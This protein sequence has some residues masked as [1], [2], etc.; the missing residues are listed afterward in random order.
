M[1]RVLDLLEELLK[2]KRYRYERLDGSTSSSSRLAAV[3]R[4]KR[5]SCQRF[6]MLLSTRAGGLGL[7]LTA[8]DI[9]IIFDSDWNPQNDLQAMARAHRIGQQRSVKIY[10]LLTAKTYEMHMFHS[11]SLKL[12]LERAVLSQNREQGDDN[13]DSK[14]KKKSDRE[15]Q[16]KEIDE[17]LKKG[18]YDVFR[19]DD[20]AEAEKF[21]E[22]D[23]DQLLENS[24]KKVTYGASSTSSL[25]NG[26]GSFSKASFVTDTGSGEKDVDLDDPD[27]WAKAVGL[28]APVE[29]PGDV[30]AML[31]DGVKRS[32][33]QVQVY[34]PYAETAAA[35]KLKMEK[36]AMEK[37][38][39]K[40]E[41]ER[42]R[43]E[44]KMKKEALKEKKK[45]EKEQK[46]QQQHKE[47][48]KKAA[49][50][51]VSTSASSSA[52]TASSKPSASKHV[53]T[54]SVKEETKKAP[55][56]TK[57]KKSKKSDRQRALRRAEN[58]NPILEQLRQAWEVQHRNRASAAILRFGFK[59]FCKVRSE[60][61]LNSLPLQDI[62]VFTRSFMFQVALQAGVNLFRVMKD[63]PVKDLRFHLRIWLGDLSE[64]EIDWIAGSIVSAMEN[65]KEVEAKRRSLRMPVILCEPSFVTDLLN[66]G[67]IR[68]LRRLGVLARLNS[69]VEKCLD[70][71]LTGLGHEEL[72]KRGC[73]SSDLSILDPDLKARFVTT[74]ELSLVISLGF[75]RVRSIAPAS[76]WDRYCDVAVS[77]VTCFWWQSKQTVFP[78]F[79]L[80]L[81]VGT[82]VHGLGNYKAMRGDQELPFSE[83]IKRSASLSYRASYQAFV[84]A[85]SAVRQVF[86]DALEA[87]RVKAEL[88]V[89]AAV[90]AAAKA[91]SKREEDAALLR[92]G[93]D[94]VE[95]VIRNMPKTQVE[96]AFEFDG[97]DSHFVTLARLHGKVCETLAKNAPHVLSPDIIPE[98]FNEGTIGRPRAEGASGRPR[99]Q[100][101][102]SMP[103]A[104]LLDHRL[105]EILAAVEGSQGQ[106][107]PLSEPDNSQRETQ[108]AM[109]GT[110]RKVVLSRFHGDR[111]NYFLREYTGVGLAGAQCGTTHRTLNDGTDFAYGSASPPLS[112]VA[113]GTDAPRYLRALGIPMNV[114]RFAVSALSYADK[115]CVDQLLSLEQR[116]FHLCDQDGDKEKPVDP[117]ATTE[118]L[119]V[120]GNESA[121]AK[122]GFRLS[123][124]QTERSR[125]VQRSNR[126][127]QTA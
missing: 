46:Q 87:G 9:V 48:E 65:H 61:N 84:V 7:N 104:R 81:V 119:S 70:K 83:K 43:L 99:S 45:R 22:T 108:T 25:G 107:E 49:A 5:K 60:A 27:F 31:D 85:A 57:P 37:M 120:S 98:E 67:A 127:S 42:A 55:V 71:I 88:E 75:K 3:D 79:S 33:K 68:A 92:E 53:P 64:Y 121:K 115:K 94:G 17:L 29:T 47:A 52:A 111:L 44:K 123:E 4:F 56:E 28:D 106:G 54:E 50:T 15:A 114:T 97:T 62:E 112:Q 41:K 10:R 39:E 36:I 58:E 122:S 66:G 96:N 125:Q 12:G 100:M 40:E 103:D 51:A 116:R 126:C 19:D 6:V 32:R 13:D 78:H 24:S 113:Y 91:A 93:G 34:D 21:M 14:S 11:A 74:E 59:R 101:M 76:W 90:A 109:L 2:I 73:A 63:S 16:A 26:L 1:V 117:A 89:Q 105:L 95:D 69:Y 72:G 30:A 118:T 80:Q 8:A 38:L 124:K 23:I 18:A 86:D 35:E 77:I 82:F 102:L 20:D 110:L